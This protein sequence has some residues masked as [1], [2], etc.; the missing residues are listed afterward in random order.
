MRPVALRH[1]SLEFDELV[2][3][4]GEALGHPLAQVPPARRLADLR[5][6][7]AGE[8]RGG[9]TLALLVDEAQALP[10]ATLG[11]LPRLVLPV[12]GPFQILLAGQPALEGRLEAA[13]LGAHVAVRVQLEPLPATAVASYVAFRLARAGAEGAKIFAPDAIA[14][15]ARLTR[16][17]P[18]LVNTIAEASL[19]EAFA[20]RAK[21]VSGEHVKAAWRGH[22]GFGPT[23]MPGVTSALDEPR[24]APTPREAH[25]PLPFEPPTRTTAVPAQWRRWP[26]AVGAGVAVGVLAALVLRFAPSPPE[27]VPVP[28]VAT[29][30]VRPVAVPAPVA[31]SLPT[32]SEALAV[33]D[34]FREAYEARDATALLALLAPDAEERDRRGKLDVVA[35]HARLLDRLDAVTYEQP[36]ARVEPRAGGVEVLAPFVL[37]LRDASGRGGAVRGTAVWRIAR[38]EGEP[39]IVALRRDLA[40]DTELPDD[41]ALLMP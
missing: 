27:T 40:P 30:P 26:A 8:A 19:V 31:E 9:D 28:V 35:A 17:V 24:P 6:A 4:V 11:A 12:G 36:E 16:G 23:V 29:P 13:G 3:Q 2:E 34:A 41:L 10:A 20:A 18:R 5:A 1:P 25:G 37:H 14:A 33:V 22:T 38:R 7:I 21:R 15:I 39:R 32:P